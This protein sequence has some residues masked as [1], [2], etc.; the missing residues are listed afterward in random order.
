[1][2][3]EWHTPGTDSLHD[4]RQPVFQAHRLALRIASSFQHS[5][6]SSFIWLKGA[7]VKFTSANRCQDILEG[8]LYGLHCL[9]E[10]QIDSLCSCFNACMDAW[11]HGCV[12]A[13]MHGCMDAWTD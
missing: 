12:D 4:N 6:E 1:M 9:H 5:I 8:S 2:T 11:M 7:A 13:W 3:A 10:E